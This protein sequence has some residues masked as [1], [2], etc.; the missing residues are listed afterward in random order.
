MVE[1]GFPHPDRLAEWHDWYMEHIKVLLT[2]PGFRAS[3]RFE[4]VVDNPSPYLALHE[5]ASAEMFQSDAYRNRGGPTSVGEW[6][7]LQTN[8]HRNLLDGLDETPEVPPD[9]SLLLLRDVRDVLVPAAIR[10]DWL[11]GVGLDGTIKECGW[12]W[13]LTQARCST[14]LVAIGLGRRF[15]HGR[16]DGYRAS[17]RLRS[18]TT[19]SRTPV[20]Q[21]AQHAN[22]LGGHCQ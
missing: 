3:Q 12:R 6:R 19:S 4:A 20:Q 14:S 10:V 8:W 16:S 2:V 22:T 15:G 18:R 1:M 7:S 13:C 11:R 21:I 9:A 5:V 17:E